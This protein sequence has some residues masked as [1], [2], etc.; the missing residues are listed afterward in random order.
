MNISNKYHIPAKELDFVN[1]NL[2][3]DNRLFIDPLRIKNGNTEIHKKCYC[4]IKRFIDIIIKLSKERKYQELLVYIQNLHERNE[5]S[6]SETLRRN[7]RQ[8]SSGQKDLRYRRQ[9]GERRLR[10]RKREFWTAWIVYRLRDQGKGE[11]GR[12]RTPA[13]REKDAGS[14]SGY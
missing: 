12:G 7:H 11:K 8:K 5:T 14:G 2:S 1:I 13:K 4:Q 3:K 6:C 10:E 9:G